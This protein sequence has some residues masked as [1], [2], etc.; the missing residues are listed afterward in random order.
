M[1]PHFQIELD[2]DHLRVGFTRCAATNA[3]LV[4]EVAELLH[5]E[6]GPPLTYAT[7]GWEDAC[8]LGR[9]SA[10]SAL[11]QVLCEFWLAASEDEF[12]VTT[13]DFEQLTGRTPRSFES[14]VRE[15]RGQFHAVRT[16]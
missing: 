11:T 9:R 16:A 6:I 12:A 3:T 7:R 10:Q 15:H 1:P 4:R 5:G 13:A 14:F 2:N 8:L